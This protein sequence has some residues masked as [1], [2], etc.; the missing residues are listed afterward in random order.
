[1]ENKNIGGVFMSINE[2]KLTYNEFKKMLMFLNSC[3][4][5]NL[6]DKFGESCEQCAYRTRY[7]KEV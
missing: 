5:D 1:M 3:E 6:C 4:K 2:E 7:I